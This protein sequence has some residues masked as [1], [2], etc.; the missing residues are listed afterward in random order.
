[1]LGK[2]LR[3]IILTLVT[4]VLCVSLIAFGTYAL[5]TDSRTLSVHL[6]AASLEIELWRT[7]LHYNSLG[8]DGYESL[9]EN[10]D[11]INFTEATDANLFDLNADS[12]IAPGCWYEATLEIRNKGTV[13][14]VWWLSLTLNG[15]VTELSKQIQITVTQCDKDGNELKNADGT[16]KMQRQGMLDAGT[17]LG[18]A[19]DPVG[20]FAISADNT[21]AVFKV[22]VEFLN[23]DTDGSIN[24]VAQNGQAAFDLTVNAVQELQNPAESTTDSTDSGSGT[25]VEP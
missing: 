9:G 7:D 21:V 24:N 23:L 4:M 11:V 15:N 19:A 8:A 13:A 1:M 6:N 3:A 17:V 18:S 20:H 14:F 5:F 22:K 25:S 2:K 12:L 10:N 16:L